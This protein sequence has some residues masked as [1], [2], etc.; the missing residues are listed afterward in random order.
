VLDLVKAHTAALQYLKNG[1]ESEVFNLGIGKGFSVLEIIEA[2]EKVIGKKIQY[3][4]AERRDGDPAILI[5][6]NN[7]AKKTLDWDCEF[8]KP[9]TI[10]EDAWRFYKTHPKGYN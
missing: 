6:S 8:V 1:G 2:A 5:A 10:I 4:I 7:K 9:E 3:E